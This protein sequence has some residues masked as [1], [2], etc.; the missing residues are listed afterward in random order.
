MYVSVRV[1]AG[2]KEEKVE[3]LAKGRLRVRVREP[4]ERNLAN[5]RVAMLVAQHFKVAAGKARLVSGHH[6]QAKIFDIEV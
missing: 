2:A 4:A 6:S 5:R 3:E 1:V